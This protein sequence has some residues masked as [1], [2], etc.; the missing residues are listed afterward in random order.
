MRALPLLARTEV[1]L[2]RR[3]FARTQ[4]MLGHGLSDGA[5]PCQPAV[6]GERIEDLSWALACAARLLPGP[7]TC[8]A[9]SLALWAWL[10]RDG[11]ESRVRIGIRRVHGQIEAHAWVE[12][13]GH[14][15]NQPPQ[16]NPEFS[17]FEDS[18]RHRPQPPPASRQRQPQYGQLR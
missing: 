3:G 5:R 4:A 1:S 6:G 17:A 9:Q 11:V 13:E 8:L 18:T 10:R 2:R 16:S 12:V 7:P 15:I 14:T